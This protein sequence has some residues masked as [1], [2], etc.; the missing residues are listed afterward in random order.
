MLPHN[1]EQAV[2]LIRSVRQGFFLS[3]SSRNSGQFSGDRMLRTCAAGMKWRISLSVLTDSFQHISDRLVQILSLIFD[4]ICFPFC[5]RG[6]VV[7]IKTVVSYAASH[8][9]VI[10]NE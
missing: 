8:E 5:R 1:L 10:G 4:V 7:K 3:S 9:V 2:E 6:E